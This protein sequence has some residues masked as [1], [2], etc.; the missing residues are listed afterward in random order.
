MTMAGG[1][2]YHVKLNSVS[3]GW[4]HIHTHT[5][6]LSLFLSQSERPCLQQ[7]I[8]VWGWTKSSLREEG[9]QEVDS[10]TFPLQGCASVNSVLTREAHS[11][12]VLWEGRCQ[13]LWQFCQP[14]SAFLLSCTPGQTQASRGFV[15]K[16][17]IFSL[18]AWIRDFSR[19][20]DR[21]KGNWSSH[22]GHVMLLFEKRHPGPVT[23]DKGH[24]P[25]GTLP[26]PSKLPGTFRSQPERT[27]CLLPG[28]GVRAACWLGPCLEPRSCFLQQIILFKGNPWKEHGPHSSSTLEAIKKRHVWNL[29]H[30]FVFMWPQWPVH[31]APPVT[32][33]MGSRQRWGKQLISPA[34][35]SVSPF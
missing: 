11:Q 25:P 18:V 14:I 34:W 30:H 1:E 10:V 4:T 8:L 32:W 17:N 21:W 29:S 24:D 2:I 12:A 22:P 15:R 28:T 3:S 19:S 27:L 5:L 35:V 26:V 9:V 6:S 13:L 33:V 31:G 16:T 7:P 23:L 20:L